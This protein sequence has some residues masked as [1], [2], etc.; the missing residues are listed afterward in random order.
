MRRVNQSNEGDLMT[1]EALALE[2]SRSGTEGED[3]QESTG[4]D[5]RGQRGLM[6]PAYEPKAGEVALA[7]LKPGERGI[8]CKVDCD[9]RIARRVLEMGV[10]PGTPVEVIRIAPL[11]D[12]VELRL[13]GYALSLRKAEVTRIFVTRQNA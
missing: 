1:D 13:R 12:P 11:G 4:Q 10:L 3:A 8:V 6:T 5:V 9:G 7:T 2:R